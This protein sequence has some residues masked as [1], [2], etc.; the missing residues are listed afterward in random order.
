[1]DGDII[2][3][4]TSYAG[5]MVLVDT[6]EAHSVGVLGKSGRGTEEHFCMEDSIDIKMGTLSKP[7]HLLA[8]MRWQKDVV[9]F[10]RHKS[11]YFL[12]FASGTS[13]R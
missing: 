7:S 6:D 11:L 13:C 8:V 12:Q 9:E 1:M 2:D 3:P 4:R 10:L 5:N